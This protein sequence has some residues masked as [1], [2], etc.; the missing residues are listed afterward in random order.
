VGASVRMSADRPP[1]AVA[2]ENS[3]LLI[4]TSSYDAT[5]DFLIP[6][7]A[8]SRVFRFN[9]D[10]FN[11]YKLWFDASGFTIADPTGRRCSSQE[12][13]K[14]YWRWPD[15]P[16]AKNPEGRYAQSEARYLVWEMAN[17]LWS[18][19]KFVLVEP[20]APRRS[21]K[22]IQL[23]R[24][25][26]FFN[27]PPFRAGINTRFSAEDGLEVVK[28]LSKN[29]PAGKF[30]F[31]TALDPSRLAPD[32]PWFMQRYVEATFDITVV[33]VRNR[34]FAFKLARNFLDRGIDWRAAAREEETWSPMQ[35]SGQTAASILEYMRAMRLDFG[36]L[37][38]LMDAAGELYF[39]EVNPN[40]QYAWLD[41]EKKFGLLSA[42]IDE[43]SPTT[44]RHSIPVVHPL[45]EI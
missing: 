16:V 5:V 28:S 6:F 38:F 41:Y 11:Q 32:M 19:G 20:G 3:T 7:L 14:A 10:L 35:L 33:V 30:I 31:S 15:W 4:I 26:Q 8:P 18:Q 17:V 23:I 29:L 27:V 44:E 9:T 24:A 39:C 12:T 43:I 37:D 36:R 13:Y 42:V 2:D 34:L 40:P 1:T 45:A 25:G 21:G 22:L